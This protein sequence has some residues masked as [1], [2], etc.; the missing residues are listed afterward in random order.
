M[1][2]SVY[3]NILLKI[4]QVGTCLARECKKPHSILYKIAKSTVHV[5]L[6]NMSGGFSCL[7]EKP[8]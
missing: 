7:E 2:I 8:M 3:I 5:E 4:R 6:L 1:Q